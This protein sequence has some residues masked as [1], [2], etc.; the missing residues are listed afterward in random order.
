MNVSSVFGRSLEA[1]IFVIGVWAI[2]HMSWG[3][4][5][6][7]ERLPWEGAGNAVVLLYY[8]V[9]DLETLLSR[10]G[11]R[12]QPRKRADSSP[13]Q[14]DDPGRSRNQIWMAPASGRDKP[15]RYTAEDRS[16]WSPRWS[17]A[18]WRSTRPTARPCDA[19][20]AA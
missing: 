7:A 18:A 10:H 8:V 20:R 1:A 6:L 15:R 12:T 16:S 9:P 14:R 3:F 13:S 17:P 2:G 5:A 11:D 19:P 4:A